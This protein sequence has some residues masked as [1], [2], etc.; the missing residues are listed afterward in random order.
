MDKE[1]PALA[2]PKSSWNPA[3]W[4]FFRTVFP[5]TP[6]L[7]F[8]FSAAG[9]CTFNCGYVDGGSRATTSREASQG[10]Q[11]YVEL[12]VSVWICAAGVKRKGVKKSV[13]VL[14]MGKVMDFCSQDSLFV[15]VRWLFNVKSKKMPLFSSLWLYTQFSLYCLKACCKNSNY[16]LSYFWMASFFRH[17]S[18]L[19]LVS[20]FECNDLST[21]EMMLKIFQWRSFLKE[22]SHRNHFLN[23][24]RKNILIKVCLIWRMK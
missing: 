12:V 10:P 19:C 22:F 23:M 21:L 7:N 9:Y 15:F 1:L 16:S 17:T 14:E 24:A 3:F 4:S 5:N 8:F 20:A 2:L 13:L 6:I 11:V 18:L